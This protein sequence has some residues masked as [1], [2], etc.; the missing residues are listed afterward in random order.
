MKFQVV[1]ILLTLVQIKSEEVAYANEAI[2]FQHHLQQQQQQQHGIMF[3]GGVDLTDAPLPPLPPSGHVPDSN[4]I[5][6]Y[7][8]HRHSRHSLGQDSFD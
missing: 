3:S 7:Q 1:I 5:E 2:I 4:Q 6:R 8:Q